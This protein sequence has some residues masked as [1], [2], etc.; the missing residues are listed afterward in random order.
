MDFFIL[1]PLSPETGYHFFE[2]GGSKVCAQ[3]DLNEGQVSKGVRPTQPAVS[4][5][6]GFDLQTCRPPAERIPAQPLSELTDMG[7]PL[8]VAESVTETPQTVWL[9]L[10]VCLPAC[11]TDCPTD[12]L[13]D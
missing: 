6:A 5:L 13:P 8:L 4:R 1:R 10:P 3:R 11:P 9:C 12:C 2:G 7:S